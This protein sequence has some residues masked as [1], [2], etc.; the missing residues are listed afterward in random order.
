MTR[1]NKQCCSKSLIFIKENG[2]FMALWIRKMAPRY[3]GILRPGADGPRSQNP[4]NIPVIMKQKH[5]FGLLLPHRSIILSHY[6]VIFHSKKDTSFR[7]FLVH[8]S[9]TAFSASDWI[10]SL[11]FVFMVAFWEETKSKV[12]VRHIL[13]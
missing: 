8:D 9:V 6:H 2:L 10:T 3:L 13:L 12:N 7:A 5:Y 11:D 1:I 4:R